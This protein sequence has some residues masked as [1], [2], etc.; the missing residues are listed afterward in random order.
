MKLQTALKRRSRPLVIALLMLSL[1][2]VGLLPF[3]ARVRGISFLAGEAKH[4]C[5][6][7]NTPDVEEKKCFGYMPNVTS[8]DF[9]HNWTR[10]GQPLAEIVPSI[11]RFYSVAVC[12]D[13]LLAGSERGVYSLTQPGTNWALTQLGI[14]GAVTDVAFVPG[15][16]ELAYAAILG[17]GIMRG[18]FANNRWTWQRVD[19]GLQDARS[20]AIVGDSVATA[21][22]YAA[23]GF[24][25]KWLPALPNAAVAW[26]GTQIESLTINL[27]SGEELVA[28]VWTDGVH[29]A[30]P[31]GWVRIG[32]AGT[33]TDSLVYRAAYDGGKGLV[34]TQTGAFLWK[35]GDWIRIPSISQ[36]GFAVALG[37]QTLFVGQRVEGVVGSRDGGVTWYK[38]NNGLGGVNDPAFQVRDLT[39]HD[40]TLYAA[41]TTGIWK[42]TGQ[43]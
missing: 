25:V 3:A 10:V 38:A 42:W 31:G 36:T 4:P 37:S 29:R 24:G 22:I 2:L 12:D 41:T 11:E 35:N 23:G 15:D 27:T 32:S 16:C 6:D 7:P 19:I 18:Q 33:P 40:G 39:I 28:A 8:V 26:E 20:V 9:R 30:A 43:P 5:D 17:Q 21:S 34:G 13:T 14:T 1:A